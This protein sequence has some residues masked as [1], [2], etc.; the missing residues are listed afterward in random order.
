MKLTNDNNLYEKNYDAP[1]FIWKKHKNLGYPLHFH[2]ALEIYFILNGQMTTVIN[3]EEYFFSAGDI[4]IINPYELH[5]YKKSGEADVAVLI[6][7]SHY[8]SDFHS[9]YGD[10]TLP[11][12]LKDKEYNRSVYALLKDLSSSVY[13]NT[14]VSTL[15]KKGLSNMIFDKIISRYG[16]ISQ[17]QSG[18]TVSN[19]LKYIQNNYKNKITLEDLAAHFGYAKNSMSRIL[20]KYLGVDLRIFVNN[21]RAEQVKLVLKDPEYKHL[22]VMQIA[23][24]CG[25][26][27][28]ATFYRTY[29]RQ[30]GQLPPK[31]E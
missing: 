11:S 5:S 20:A 14:S 16:V 7:S 13:D 2:S 23:H 26:D 15:G 1:S 21:I 19:I 17:T 25:F 9:E 10:K 31:R 4:S 27:S 3:G 22:S 18:T 12:S 30:Y 24:F 6:L 8:L 29:K 28:A